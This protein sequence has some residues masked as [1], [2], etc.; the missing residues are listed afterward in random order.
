MRHKRIPD[1][2]ARS[3]TI[4]D[5]LARSKIIPKTIASHK[6]IPN[7]LARR[8]LDEL[9][10]GEL[11]HLDTATLTPTDADLRWQR[12]RQHWVTMT[13]CALAFASLHV[14]NWKRF[15]CL[16]FIDVFVLKFVSGAY[17]CFCLE[18]YIPSHSLCPCEW[19][20]LL[21]ALSSASHSY[22]VTSFQSDFHVVLC[23]PGE[24]K[25]I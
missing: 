7:P 13:E 9:T 20:A 2:L 22:S 23:S 11:P 12:H 18:V 5:P 4:P 15:V 21:W 17:W 25:I 16:V 6:I 19:R 24:C 10:C 14:P 8:H 3:K 1:P